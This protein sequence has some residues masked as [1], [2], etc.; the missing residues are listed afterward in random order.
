MRF[1]TLFKVAETNSLHPRN[2]IVSGNSGDILF[3]INNSKF[4]SN[5]QWGKVQI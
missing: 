1:S 5:V 4:C 3:P 2:L